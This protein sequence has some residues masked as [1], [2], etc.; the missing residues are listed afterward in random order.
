MFS[1][2]LLWRVVFL[3]YLHHYSANRIVATLFLSRSTVYRV[4]NRFNTD[5]SV[6]GPAHHRGVRVVRRDKR[7]SDHDNNVLAALVLSEASIYL[8]ELADAL[9]AR[10]GTRASMPT[11]CRALRHEM[12]ITRKRVRDAARTLTTLRERLS[13]ARGPCSRPR[14]Y[15][16]ACRSVVTRNAAV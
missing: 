13:F 11:I 7:L 1:A 5:R 15:A 9:H 4:I 16:F 14:A 12:R 8:D 6:T 10:T 2:D 3:W